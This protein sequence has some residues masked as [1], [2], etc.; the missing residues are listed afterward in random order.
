MAGKSH[1]VHDHA[2]FIAASK[3][4]FGDQFDYGDT[5]YVNSHTSLVLYCRHHEPKC[6]V[7]ITPDR[8]LRKKG[9]CHQCKAEGARARHGS[10]KEKFV[11]AAREIHGDNFGYDAVVYLNART[12]VEI[13]CRLHKR[14][15]KQVPDVHLRGSSGCPDC[16]SAKIRQS[17]AIL[18]ANRTTSFDEFLR[19]ARQQHG[20]RYTYDATSYVAMNKNVRITCAQHGVFTQRAQRHAD[21][22]KCK[23]CINEELRI[24]EKEWRTRFARKF[25]KRLTSTCSGEWQGFDTPVTVTCPHHGH[26]WSTTAKTSIDGNGCRLCNREQKTEPRLQELRKEIP[27]ELLSLHQSHD[28]KYVEFVIRAAKTHGSRYSYEQEHFLS[29]SRYCTVT[30]NTHGQFRVAPKAHLDGSGCP[31]C[32]YQVTFIEEA[33]DRFKGLYDYSELSFSRRSAMEEIRIRCIEHNE[34][35]TQIARSHIHGAPGCP[36]CTKA[37][38]RAVILQ[39]R[40]INKPDLLKTFRDEASRLHGG[41]Y[42]YPN[43]EAELETL[44]SKVTVYCPVHEY[45]FMPQAAAHI[46]DGK[47]TPAGC[48]RCKGDAARQRNRTPYEEVQER[49]ARLGFA[50]MTPSSEYKNMRQTVQARCNEGHDVD[51]IPQKI[52]AGRGCPDCSPYVGEAIARSVLESIFESSFKK[53]R[54]YK[55]DYPELIAPYASLELDGYAI[56]IRTAFE[57]QGAWHY[58]RSMH[59]SD[60]DYEK[61]QSRDKKKREMCREMD[62]ALIEVPEFAYPFEQRDILAKMGT[63]IEKS[64]TTVRFVIPDSLCLKN[65]LPLLHANGLKRLKELAAAHNL[66]V[67]EQSWHGEWH[68]YHWKCNKCDHEFTADYA[69]RKKAKWECCP[70]CAR[71]LPEVRAE[72]RRSRLARNAPTYLTALKERT[73]KLGLELQDTEWKGSG[74]SVTYRFVCVHTRQ[75]TRPLTYNNIQKLIFGCRCQVHQRLKQELTE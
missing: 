28:P 65:H 19:R 68:L 45:T 56:D 50:L 8:H 2:T 31:V 11:A 41:K 21:G 7:E 9:G 32:E 52:L 57:Y 12:D 48:Q 38:R 70:R 15:F 46:H 51:V 33:S 27:H 42:E 73:A 53:K 20:G 72:A 54:F 37:H 61:Q 71:S 26:E 25:G 17:N 62:I 47:R 4:R 23:Q 55:R 36:S 64:G 35:F 1:R 39:R 5:Q 10:S 43:L 34:V 74:K 14:S 69:V 40:V 30:C 18:Y 49:L 66:T 22:A 29:M 58:M 3:A 60:Q 16:K 6:K 24:S 63:A 75:E 13:Y 67:R 59:K 44:G